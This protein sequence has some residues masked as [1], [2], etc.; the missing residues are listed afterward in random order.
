[1]LS[2]TNTTSDYQGWLELSVTEGISKWLIDGHHNKGL[3]IGAHAVNRAEHEVKLDDIGLVNTKG[4]DEYQPFM[5]GYFKGQDIVKPVKHIGTRVKR[6]APNKRKKKSEMRNPLLD[7]RPQ[8]SHK[9]C[10]IQTLYVSFKDLKWQVSLSSDLTT[11]C[12]HTNI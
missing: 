9:S 7:Q 5:V 3:Y 11:Q 8:E 12:C 6:S 1:M 4:D 2:S 10:Q